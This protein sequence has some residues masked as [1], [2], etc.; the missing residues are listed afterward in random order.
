[1]FSMC[2]YLDLKKKKRQQ[3]NEHLE[4]EKE[5]RLGLFATWNKNIPV[6]CCPVSGLYPES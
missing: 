1:M 4:E 2:L 5:A 6:L 3:L